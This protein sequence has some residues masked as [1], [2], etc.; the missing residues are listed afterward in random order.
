MF[1]VRRVD[2]SFVLPVGISTPGMSVCLSVGS[3]FPKKDLL[4]LAAASAV[5][6]TIDWHV[7]VIMVSL[8]VRD[9]RLVHWRLP[10]VVPP[11]S[12]G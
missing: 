2:C 5:P 10:T 8:A 9:G 11:T 6:V 1:G 12:A 7:V 4:S 3:A